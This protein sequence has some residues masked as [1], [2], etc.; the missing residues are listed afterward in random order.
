LPIWVSQCL[1][2]VLA[3]FGKL[4]ADEIEKWARL[5]KLAGI[6]AEQT[7][8]SPPNIPR[9]RSTKPVLELCRNGEM[10][11]PDRRDDLPHQETLLAG[12]FEALEG[13]GRDGADRSPAGCPLMVRPST[14]EVIP[15]AG[16]P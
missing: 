7:R 14:A 16:W 12:C 1:Q 6:K 2:G 13:I 3:E 15:A 4:I 5:V 8:T 11:V 10:I 9:V